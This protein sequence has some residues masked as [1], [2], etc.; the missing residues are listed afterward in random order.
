MQLTGWQ[1]RIG[2][3][4]N[5]FTNTT[6]GQVMSLANT[7][8]QVTLPGTPFS[9]EI[10]NKLEQAIANSEIIYFDAAPTTETVGA[11]G[12]F[13][14]YDGMV[15]YCSGVSISM[16]YGALQ[17]GTYFFWAQN[18][19]YSFTITE[20][21]ESLT[22]DGATLTGTAAISTNLWPQGTEIILTDGSTY[23]WTELTPGAATIPISNTLALSIGL[24]LSSTIADALARMQTGLFLSSSPLGA[25]SAGTGA[26]AGQTIRS[27]AYDGAKYVAAVDGQNALTSAD[28]ITW[29]ALSF[30]T[31]CFDGDAYSIAYGGGT[32]VAVGAGVMSSPSAVSASSWTAV[33]T[34]PSGTW[35]GVAY[36]GGLWVIG[37]TGGIYTSPDLQSWTQRKTDAMSGLYGTESAVYAV[38]S[39]GV[40][41]SN[42]GVNWSTLTTQYGGGSLVADVAGNVIVY[43]SGGLTAYAYTGGT[44]ATTTYD[45]SGPAIYGAFLL[46]GAP[47]L[48]NNAGGIW[49]FSN[50]G[51]SVTSIP[52]SPAYAA[53]VTPYMIVIGGASGGLAYSKRSV[54]ITTAAGASIIHDF[55]VDSGTSGDWEYRVYSSGMAECWQFVPNSQMTTFDTYRYATLTFPITFASAPTVITGDE[56]KTARIDQWA[57]VMTCARAVTTTSMQVAMQTTDTTHGGVSVH[58]M[59]VLA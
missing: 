24:P 59:G 31:S 56:S 50:P 22:F 52:V 48:L 4:L 49:A 28:G 15:Y 9:P 55:V 45:D 20:A 29:A 33:G 1:P 44:W 6:T 11:L 16:S 34:A 39:S 43:T 36:I 58:V 19:P 13:G 12:Q 53:Y 32:F 40:Y 2:T 27:I 42:D 38:N 35:Y 10:M 3:G 37:G 54:E 14:A 51:T 8:A 30:A 41:V 57:P 18:L 25:F 7:P 5:I 47:Y 23:Q 17:P 21:V 46:D 26:L